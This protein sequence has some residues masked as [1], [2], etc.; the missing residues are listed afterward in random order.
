MTANLDIWAMRK[1]DASEFHSGV[2]TGGMGFH[3]R[4]DD[5]NPN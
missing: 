3:A 2:V 1:Q 4:M 5:E